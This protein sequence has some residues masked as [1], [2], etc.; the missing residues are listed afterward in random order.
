MLWW[1]LLCGVPAD[2]PPRLD[3]ATVT[4]LS[5]PPDTP[6]IR[7]PAFLPQPAPGVGERMP[8]RWSPAF[9]RWR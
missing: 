4:A 6:L 3:P 8:P 1:L 2:E 5:F 9:R 7:F